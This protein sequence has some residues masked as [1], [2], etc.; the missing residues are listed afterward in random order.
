MSTGNIHLAAWARDLWEKIVEA[1]RGLRIT[2]PTRK[3]AI[4][5]RFAL[6]GAR[7]INRKE[8]AEFGETSSP[9]DAYRL[10]IEVDPTAKDDNE[11]AQW[12]LIISLHSSPQFTPTSI[13]EL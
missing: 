10:T 8:M 12:A 3:A 1:P 6:Y 4:A 7:N 9:W 13:E 11:R 2:Y 5:A